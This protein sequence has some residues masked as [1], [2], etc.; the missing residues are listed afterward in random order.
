MTDLWI[1]NAKI[2]GSN[3]SALAATIGVTAG[4]I[5]QVTVVP[6]GDRHTHRELNAPN[7]IDAGNRLLTPGLIDL[8]IHGI[9]QWLFESSPEDLVAGL[10]TL[11]KYGVTSVLPT[12]YRCMGPE[13]V[14]E[15]RAL[16]VALRSCKG[17]N[18]HGFHLE[19]PFLR[20][21]GAGGLTMHGDV[22]HLD[23]LLDAADGLVAAMS[24]SPDTPGIVPVIERLVDRDVVPFITH[25]QA[26]YEQTRE[27]I[28]AGARHATHFYDVF[29]SPQEAD[30]G[31]RPV[32]CVEAVLEDPNVSVDFIVDGVHVHPG[33][34]RLALRCK[35]ATGVCLITDA[36][37]GAGM[38]PGCYPTPWGFEVEVGS[39]FGG[40]RIADRDN[41]LLGQLAGSALTM[42][43][44]I[45]NTHRF[46]GQSGGDAWLMATK[47]P[48][49]VMGWDCKGSLAPGFDADLVLWDE[50]A[51][52]NLSAAYT[53]VQ[54]R[55]VHQDSKVSEEIV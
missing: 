48:A 20:L 33:A 53:W 25:T 32:G 55:C 15:L 44:A 1:E 35:G 43:Q 29:L 50:D 51:Y 18:M 46:L 22:A 42:P 45:A 39:E 40:A 16:A 26:T 4:R 24:I 28:E 52:G 11:P 37:I 27:A 10:E 2:V 36:N 6:P 31:V 14:H 21:A 13:H 8:H 12:L 49:T 5:S 19:G 23:A 38:P 30:S 41:P 3:G 17:L 47:N 7:R 9:E 54:G 34:I